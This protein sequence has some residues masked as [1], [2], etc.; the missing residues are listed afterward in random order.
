MPGRG[1]APP[2]PVLGLLPPLLPP[3]IGVGNIF[4]PQQFFLECLYNGIDMQFG[5]LVIPAQHFEN[6]QVI[7]LFINGE[8]EFLHIF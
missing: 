5:I 6:G 2:P 4:G 1:V 3:T 7:L 8:M